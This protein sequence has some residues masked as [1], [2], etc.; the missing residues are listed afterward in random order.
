[1]WKAAFKQKVM[2]GVPAPIAEVLQ[3]FKRR[4]PNR[5]IYQSC[6]RGKKGLEIGG[7]SILF[8]TEL[9]LYEQAGSL[10]GLNF[11]GDTVWEGS[12]TKGETY[13]YCPGRKGFQFISEATDLA[14][15]AA[16]TY[17]FILSSNCL[18]HVANPIRALFEWKRV[19]RPGGALILVV[20]NK[21]NNFD[22]RRPF[23]SFEH[24]VQDYES[25]VSE[26]DLT[27]VDEILALHDL[28]M[29]PQAGSP[30][31]FR[32]RSLDNFSNRCLHHHV[33]EPE[34][35]AKTLGYTGFTLIGT[36]V[37]A[38]DFFSVSRRG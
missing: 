1:M 34:T 18:E 28:S 13:A 12:I 23:T 8:R 19:L 11:S 5:E 14:Q 37:T 22:H 2:R 10:D 30:E 24:L 31:A 27:H 38:G 20:P 3:H 7:P 25:G 9:P 29:D 16:G 35:V 33:F 21:A 36:T 15:I 26:R 17:D 32:A 4:L 6:V